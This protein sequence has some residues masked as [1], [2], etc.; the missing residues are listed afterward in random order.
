MS[1]E[2]TAIIDCLVEG[3]RVTCLQNESGKRVWQCGCSQ[4][5][6]RQRDLGEGFCAHTALAIA[7]ALRDELIKPK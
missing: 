1:A 6:R 7:H 3:M 5:A 4:F 2:T